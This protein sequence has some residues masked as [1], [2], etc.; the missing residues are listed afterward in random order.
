MLDPQ[1][2]NEPWV[3]NNGR[4]AQ[5][6]DSLN[7]ERP[8]PDLVVATGDLTNNGEP[9]EL[10]ELQRLLEPLELPLM[11]LPGNHDDHE[12]FRTGFDMPWAADDHMSWTLDLDELV[13]VGLDITVPGQLYG[14]FDEVKEQWLQRVLGRAVGRPTL[15][16][17]HHPPFATGITAMDKTMV[18][19]ADAFLELVSA[20]PHV[21]RI[22]C[23]HIH[24]PVVAN[25]AGVTASVCL[26]TVHHIGLN[27]TP[28][29]PIEVIRDPAGYQ[30][31]QYNGRSWITHSRYIDTGE[32]SFRP[33]W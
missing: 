1:N 13:L 6:I 31:H 2:Q 20:H 16:A 8:R 32:K 5:A 15:I 3:D 12:A 4:L 30:L 24:R 19:G 22:I 11:V 23:G 21:K 7:G 10:A 33:N 27:L 29:A 25:L 17:M 26:S 28:D 14:R 18:R 9:A